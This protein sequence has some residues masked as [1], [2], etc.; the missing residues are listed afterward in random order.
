[1]IGLVLAVAFSYLV[2]ASIVAAVSYP[3]AMLGGLSITRD[4]FLR[5]TG[6]CALAVVVLAI[7]VA[8][9]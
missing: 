4:R 9:I 1:M 6:W 7:A 3:F 8:S 2:G 5:W